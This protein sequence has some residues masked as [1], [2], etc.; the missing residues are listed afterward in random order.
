M[1]KEGQIY[2]NIQPRFAYIFRII[3][4]PHR[5]GALLGKTLY[6]NSKWI[7]QTFY[8]QPSTENIE[9]Q[10]ENIELLSILLGLKNRHEEKQTV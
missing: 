10:E 9:I 1:L 6:A 7:G 2:L 5:P 8:P 4:N 3:A